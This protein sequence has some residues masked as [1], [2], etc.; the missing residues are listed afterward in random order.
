MVKESIKDYSPQYP[1]EWQRDDFPF[2]QRFE[3]TNKA[4][5]IRH[6]IL[7]WLGELLNVYV[8]NLPLAFK[9]EGKHCICY[10]N[11]IV[12]KGTDLSKLEKRC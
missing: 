6:A 3:Y 11:N 12:P 8:P 7:R 1:I 9:M 4:P 2:F 5:K 10:Y